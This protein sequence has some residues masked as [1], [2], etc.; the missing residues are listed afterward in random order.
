MQWGDIES[1]IFSLSSFS[2]VVVLVLSLFAQFWRLDYSGRIT[3]FT[4][5]VFDLITLAVTPLIYGLSDVDK[6]LTRYVWY[7]SFAFVALSQMILMNWFHIR[8]RVVKSDIS[9]SIM[10]LLMCAVFINIIRFMDRLVFET[11]LLGEAYRYGT[12]SLKLI[13]LLTFVKWVAK[14][15]GVNFAS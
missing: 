7:T 2:W 13:A 1:A 3:I 5:V 12:M 4:W 8:F 11:D 15:K 10:F 14:G 6:N 9:R